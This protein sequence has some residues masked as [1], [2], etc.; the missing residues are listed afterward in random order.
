MLLKI[1]DKTT[2]WIAYAVVI[3]IS[4][5]FALWG[6]QEYFGLDSSATVAKIEDTEITVTQLE[7]AVLEKKREL[8]EA[9]LDFEPSNQQ[10]QNIVLSELFSQ[11]LITL[12]V[13]RYGLEVSDH[14][15]AEFIKQQPSFQTDQQFDPDLYTD[16][17]AS[18]GFS[19]ANFERLQRDALKRQQLVSAIQISSF[20]LPKEQ[21]HYIELIKQERKIRYLDIDYDS[22]IEPDS[23]TSE[24]AKEQYEENKENYLSPHKVKLDYIEIKLQELE[25]K[26]VV[27]DE[28]AETYYEEHADN[29]AT[30]EQFKLRHIL[31]STDERIEV[32]AQVE[33]GKL[34]QQLVEGADFSELAQEFSED[35]LTA[36]DGGELPEL[37]REELAN[38][39]VREAIDGLVEGEF[40]EPILTQYGVQIFQLVQRI[41]PQLKPFTEVREELIG[42]L[43]YQ[44]AI[45]NYADQISDLDI[46]SYEDEESFFSIANNRYGY[47]KQSTDFLDLAGNEGLLAYPKIKSI[48]NSE[49]LVGAKGN[50]GLIE[51]EEGMHAFFVSIMDE[52]PSVQQ[53]FEQVE[54]NIIA[55]LTTQKAQEKGEEERKSWIS[56]LK[57]GTINLTTIASQHGGEVQDLG[58]I[59]RNSGEVP[60]TIIRAAFGIYSSKKPAYKA[61]SL[62]SGFA[63]IALDDIRETKAMEDDSDDDSIPQ[64]SI[65]N[66][67]ITG[68]LESSQDT[69]EVKFYP[70]NL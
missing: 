66:R 70:E 25:D 28:Q 59:K 16:V 45:E 15:L 30:A 36:K 7:R 22:F 6:I 60:A 23:V 38:D 39:Q 10:I 13:E 55:A 64:Y 3:F 67:E 62:G 29:Y 51:V 56:E 24:Q 46:V 43:K 40:T 42:D 48:V 53:S 49:L 32:A 21:Q 34:H 54:Q 11:A 41:E 68:V 17:L 20:V 63:I 4:I 26:Q 27:S 8:D 5:P 14:T 44:Y 58:Y 12:L 1:K 69:F 18:Q 50:S 31:V 47:K 57:S 65:G 61:V 52:V 2:G 19:V 37:T 9:Q 35:T 33:A